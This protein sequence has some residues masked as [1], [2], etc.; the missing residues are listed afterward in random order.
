MKLVSKKVEIKRKTCYNYS[1]I[2]LEE[3]LMMLY[4]MAWEELY[5]SQY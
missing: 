4:E 1:A 5:E 3:G 2:F